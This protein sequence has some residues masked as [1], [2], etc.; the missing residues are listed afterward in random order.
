MNVVFYYAL[1][2][3]LVKHWLRYG[4]NMDHCDIPVAIVH[5]FGE[6]ALEERS[7]LPEDLNAV[8]ELIED[9]SSVPKASALACLRHNLTQ[10]TFPEEARTYVGG[11]L[12]SIEVHGNAH[13]Q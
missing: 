12:S 8:F 7:M 6:L 2:G 10:P 1:Y 4:K 11:L 9:D 3:A 5:R 13:G